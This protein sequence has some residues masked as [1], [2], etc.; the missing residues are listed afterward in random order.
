MSPNRPLF[1]S[2]QASQQ[3]SNLGL[4]SLQQFRFG[5]ANKQPTG[6]GWPLQPMGGYGA[7]TQQSSDSFSSAWSQFKFGT[8]IY[9]PNCVTSSSQPQSLFGTKIPQAQQNKFGLT[10]QQTRGFSFGIA[11]HQSPYPGDGSEP[12]GSVVLGQNVNTETEE[13]GNSEAGQTGNNILNKYSSIKHK[14]TNIKRRYTNIY[15]NL[16]LVLYNNYLM[17]IC[18]LK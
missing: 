16:I 6:L 1:G 14:Y 15:Y 9:E 17:I 13:S 10:R 18:C 4:S 2:L 11:G 12:T 8:A 5:T 7:V 3:S